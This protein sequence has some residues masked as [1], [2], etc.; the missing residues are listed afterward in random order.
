[1]GEKVDWTICSWWK[2]EAWQHRPGTH[3]GGQRLF[4]SFQAGMDP[5]YQG[6]WPPPAHRWT[7]DTAARLGETRLQLE[8]DWD[9]LL[10]GRQL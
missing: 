1:M 6:V 10:D 4:S 8:K 2:K 5:L 9:E 7:Q 3:A